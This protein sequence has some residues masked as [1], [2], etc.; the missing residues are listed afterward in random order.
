MTLNPPGM[1]G[2]ALASLGL[3]AWTGVGFWAD[4]PAT[5]STTSSRSADQIPGCSIPATPGR[6]LWVY[7]APQ[8]STFNAAPAIAD[9]GTLFVGS[10]SSGLI[11]ALTCLGGARWSIDTRTAFA[12]APGRHRFVGSGALAD[13]GTLFVGTFQGSPPV[14][15]ALRPDGSLAR[16]PRRPVPIANEISHVFGSPAISASGRVYFGTTDLSLTFGTLLAIH[17]SGDLLPEYPMLGNSVTSSPVVL[18][19]GAAVF[20]SDVSLTL[21]TV[22]P[23]PAPTLMPSPT[24][25]SSATPS[26][27]PTATR[28]PS[29]TPT[30]P[31]GAT[32][33]T[34]PPST[35]LVLPL[36]LKSQVVRATSRDLSITPAAMAQLHVLRD[37]EPRRIIDIGRGQLSEMAV[38]GDVVFLQV[39]GER[40]RLVA[41]A[42]DAEP[43]RLL[44]EH[45]TGVDIAG[46]PILGHFDAATG[47]VELIYADERGNLVSLNAPATSGADG[48]PVFNWA[49]TLDA[50]VFGAPALGDAGQVYVVAGP[51]VVAFDRSD[52][53]ETWRLDLSQ[54]VSAIVGLANVR[55]HLTLAPGGTL[56]FGSRAG[57]VAVSTE[58]RGLD[59]DALWP[60][61]RHDRRNTGRA[62]AR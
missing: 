49:V 37:G 30:S 42:L 55:G 23:P 31:G 4:A 51:T 13:D 41:I 1:L 61:L 43:P 38:A 17:P 7:P 35:D 36:L 18:A 11:V 28:T 9:D 54:S 45:R 15:L 3:V 8:V 46:G 12:N 22:L 53:S 39:F 32:T 29:A 34:Q 14:V 26:A 20:A 10:S 50:P 47:R 16:E 62:D 25:T 27:T 6:F 24:F 21:M 56:L 2:L 33:T 60:T 52:G 40:P 5:T 57:L 58:S 19:S 44:W 48:P 59:P